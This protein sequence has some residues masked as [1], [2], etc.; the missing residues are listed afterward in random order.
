MNERE[1]GIC[2][3]KNLLTHSHQQHKWLW[4]SELARCGVAK[5]V[6]R[7]RQP[8]VTTATDIHRARAA[9]CRVT[10]GALAK[11]IHQQTYSWLTQK[12]QQQQ[13]HHDKMK[14]KK[15]QHQRIIAIP[16]ISW[17][18]FWWQRNSSTS[19]SESQTGHIEQCK[20]DGWKYS[21]QII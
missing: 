4:L 20:C 14:K 2:T 3:R 15:Q 13:Q 1:P 7:C 21:H 18:T 17:K 16:I 8:Q 6:V 12:T 19:N 5:C 9:Q 11:H 10:A